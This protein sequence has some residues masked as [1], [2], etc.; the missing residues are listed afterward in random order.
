VVFKVSAAGKEK[1]LYN[2]TGG[3]DGNEPSFGSLIRDA[4]GNLYGTVLYGG[5]PPGA[6]VVYK[7]DK[8]GALRVLYT[9]TGGSDGNGPFSGVVRDSAGSL[10]GTTN[11]GGADGY[12][13]AFEL[14]PN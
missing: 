14:K 1:V 2:F 13:V 8:A 6:G 10:Y 5:G 3:T 7:L 12:G 11:S 9:F 4:S